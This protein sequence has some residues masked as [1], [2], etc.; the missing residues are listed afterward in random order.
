[1]SESQIGMIIERNTQN[2][3]EI[4]LAGLQNMTLD[5]FSRPLSTEVPLSNDERRGDLHISDD[6]KKKLVYELRMNSEEISLP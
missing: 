1:M 2:G 4:Q 6:E 3:E 5:M